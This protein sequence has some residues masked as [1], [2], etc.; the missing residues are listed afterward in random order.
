MDEATLIVALEPLLI[1]KFR[2]KVPPV[3]VYRSVPPWKTKLAAAL[4]EAPSELG[5]PPAPT[6]PTVATLNVP[7]LSVVAPE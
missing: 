6:M 7:P 4:D 1:V 2:S 5:V 3:P